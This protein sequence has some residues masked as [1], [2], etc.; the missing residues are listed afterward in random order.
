V[1]VLLNVAL[2]FIEPIAASA[3]DAHSLAVSSFCFVLAVSHANFPNIPQI[4]AKK[5]V[6][7]HQICYTHGKRILLHLV[8]RLDKD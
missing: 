8:R 3:D 2:C 4:L 7:S 5:L 6:L 1:H